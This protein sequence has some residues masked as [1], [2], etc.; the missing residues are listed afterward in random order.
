MANKARSNTTYTGHLHM[1][2][3]SSHATMPLAPDEDVAL[4]CHIWVKS[5]EIPLFENIPLNGHA[6]IINVNSLVMWH[7]PQSYKAGS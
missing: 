4:L 1:D 7:K 6:E 2:A 5:Q 3:D